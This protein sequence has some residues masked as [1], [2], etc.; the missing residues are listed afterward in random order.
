MLQISYP[1]I[2]RDLSWH[3]EVR[4]VA[5]GELA[6]T[7]HGGTL[8]ACKALADDLYYRH[9]NITRQD[10]YRWKPVPEAVNIRDMFS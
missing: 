4:N 2:S 10:D 9:P 5:T 7:V 3:A 6:Y 1:K 8:K